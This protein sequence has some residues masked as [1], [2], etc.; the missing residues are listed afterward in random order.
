MTQFLDAQ[1]QS[2]ESTLA[3]EMQ[4]RMQLEDQLSQERAKCTEVRSMRVNK[5][6]NSKLVLQLE[7]VSVQLQSVQFEYDQLIAKHVVLQVCSPRYCGIVLTSL[8]GKF[9]DQERTVLELG[10]TL[11]KNVELVSEFQEKE[12]AAKSWEDD[13]AATECKACTKP[14]N[15]SRR[16]VSSAQIT[17]ANIGDISHHRKHHCRNCGG[18]YCNVWFPLCF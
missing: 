7:K 2:L 10:E 4:T 3:V 13:S 5:N 11:S 1:R 6:N 18:I 15:V 8:Q 9:R 17:I 14:F 12:K 16:F